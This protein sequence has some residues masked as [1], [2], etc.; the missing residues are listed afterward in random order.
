[1]DNIAKKVVIVA[2]GRQNN[3]SACRLE[4]ICVSR[5]E[6]RIPI[7]TQSTR[8]FLYLFLV[9][10]YRWRPR[11]YMNKNKNIF[12]FVFLFY[13]PV[14]LKVQ[15]KKHKLKSFSPKAQIITY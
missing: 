7:L 3:N 14:V 5:F 9:F 15:N 6:S 4:H 13:V 2:I 1:M 8:W 11:F 10:T 12:V